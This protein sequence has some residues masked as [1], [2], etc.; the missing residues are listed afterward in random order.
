VRRVDLPSL[1]DA[2]R[3]VFSNV[4]QR[5]DSITIDCR[6]SAGGEQR[7][8]VASSSVAGGGNVS[9]G[10]EMRHCRTRITP[11]IA[12]DTGGPAKVVA[13][14]AAPRQTDRCAGD[15][16]PTQQQ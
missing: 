11:G 1:G 7:L 13:S 4:L 15:A 16:T 9:T 12:A 10:N 14:K 6:C 2:R 3:R 8:M 5:F